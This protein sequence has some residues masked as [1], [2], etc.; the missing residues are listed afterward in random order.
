MHSETL[1]SPGPSYVILNKERRK[2]FG[3]AL[4]A[5]KQR[6]CVHRE[7]N[8]S[9][10]ADDYREMLLRVSVTVHRQTDASVL[11]FPF[12]FPEVQSVNKCQ[13]GT[14]HSAPA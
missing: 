12:V 11:S 8:G 14:S 9:P 4:S 2:P 1:I 10:W 3:E 6:R 13:A 7:M 5:V